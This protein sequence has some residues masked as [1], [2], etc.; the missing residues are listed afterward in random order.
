M[1][2][3][4]LR[5]DTEEKEAKGF[6]IKEGKI[7]DCRRHAVVHGKTVRQ[8]AARTDKTNSVKLQVLK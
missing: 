3:V 6:K 8:K 4:I 7:S 2:K 1:L 5:A